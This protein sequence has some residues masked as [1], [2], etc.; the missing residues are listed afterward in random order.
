[1]VTLLCTETGGD[2]PADGPSL[3]LAHWGQNVTDRQ[4]DAFLEDLTA[5]MTALG[6][7]EVEQNELLAV[8]GPLRARVVPSTPVDR[9]G[10]RR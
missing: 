4:F 8:V 5:A 10:P 7:E 6:I 9:P 2:C 1:M 3:E